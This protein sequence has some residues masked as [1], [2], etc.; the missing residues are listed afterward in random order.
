MLREGDNGDFLACPRFPAC[1][2]TEPLPEG[3]WSK[4]DH[5]TLLLKQRQAY[6]KKCNHT[7][8]V[9]SRVLGKFSGKP[10]PNCFTRCECNQETDHYQPVNIE[11]FDFPM[12][13]TFRGHSYEYCG[14]VDPA[15][16]GDN[17]FPPR[18]E[19]ISY[20]VEHIRSYVAPHL[21]EKITQLETDVS[22][23]K[24]GYHSHSDKKRTNTNYI[25]SNII[26]EKVSTPDKH[27]TPQHDDVI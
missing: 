11:D 18:E 6:C 19:P 24:K 23:L 1:R 25:Y 13:D 12:S 15:S 9:P 20:K 14:Q 27:E 17:E 26:E 8:L 5:G 16:M 2:Y 22:G 7:G 4:G 10:I 21:S 3:A